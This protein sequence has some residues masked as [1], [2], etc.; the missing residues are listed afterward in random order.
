M[1]NALSSHAHTYVA[2][3]ERCGRSVCGAS[4]D[5][6]DDQDAADDNGHHGNG[7]T[8]YIYIYMYIYIYIHNIYIYT[9]NTAGEVHRQ[10]RAATSHFVTNVIY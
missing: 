4:D 1:G 5:G 6:I 7:R 8:I 2:L 3:R 9:Y 10:R